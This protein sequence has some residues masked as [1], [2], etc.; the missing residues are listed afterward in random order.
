M[1]AL[2]HGDKFIDIGSLEY[3]AKLIGV[4][5]RTISFYMSPTYKKRTNYNGWIVIKIEKD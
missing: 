4:G 5:K 3:L 1:Y 2:Y